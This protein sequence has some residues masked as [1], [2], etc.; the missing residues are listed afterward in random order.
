MKADVLVRRKTYCSSSPG[1]SMQQTI[2]HELGRRIKN[3]FV[4]VP[5]FPIPGFLFP[6]ITAFLETEPKALSS[7]VDAMSAPFR[8]NVPEAVVCVESFGYVFGVPIALALGSRVVLARR[9][10]KLPR[11]AVRESYS[12]CYDPSRHIEIHESALKA[13]ERVL[14]VD[15]I[16]GSGGTI[17]AVVRLVRRLGAEVAGATCVAEIPSLN[18]RTVIENAACPLYTLIEL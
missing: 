12:M 4:Y 15:D 11:R 13:G 9:P 8:S 3:S 18:G 10:G 6:D 16:V 1:V 14:I 17:G 2:D 7:V 5:D